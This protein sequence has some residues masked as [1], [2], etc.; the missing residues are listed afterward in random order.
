MSSIEVEIYETAG[1]KVPFSSWVTKLK[2]IQASAKILLRLD[3]VRQGNLGDCKFVSDGMFELRVSTG[4]G[5]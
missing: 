2:N 4:A 1:G 5:Y 3:R